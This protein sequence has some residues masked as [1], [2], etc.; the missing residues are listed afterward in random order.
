MERGIPHFIVD[1][2]PLPQ[3]SVV[4][5]RVGAAPRSMEGVTTAH[6]E[7]L[8]LTDRVLTGKIRL[9]ATAGAS[10]NVVFCP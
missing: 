9:T 5:S 4:R 6:V 8:A 3:Q 1:L 7:T 10:A 2:W